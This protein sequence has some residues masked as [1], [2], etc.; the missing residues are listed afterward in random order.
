MMR[1]TNQVTTGFK[2]QGQSPHQL[3]VYYLKNVFLLNKLVVKVQINNT[4][5]KTI[6]VYLFPLITRG[7]KILNKAKQI[8]MCLKMT[9][10]SYLLFFVIVLW[11]TVFP[12]IKFTHFVIWFHD[13]LHGF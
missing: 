4:E 11:L 2:C 9:G 6:I 5:S 13:N 1:P 12:S 7:F 3:S 10:K 8:F